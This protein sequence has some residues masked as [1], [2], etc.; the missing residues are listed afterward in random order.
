MKKTSICLLLLVVLSCVSSAAISI[1]IS[2]VKAGLAGGTL[3]LSAVIEK[4]FR[5]FLVDYELG[6]GVGNQ[7][8]VLTGGISGKCYIKPNMYAGL[9]INYSSYSDPVSLSLGGNVSDRAGFGLGAF[10]G[11]NLKDNMYAQVGFETRLGGI[12]E[13]GYSF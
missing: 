10:I 6:L 13:I 1:P 12:A 3:R 9:G 5:D 2:S 8:S 7:Y 4:P 11:T